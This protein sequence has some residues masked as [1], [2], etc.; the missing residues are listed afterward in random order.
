MYGATTGL[1]ADHRTV[2]TSGNT[3]T[4]IDGS[5]ASGTIKIP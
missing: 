3:T 5:G 1:N 4:K 2:Y